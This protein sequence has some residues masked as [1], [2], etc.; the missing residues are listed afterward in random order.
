MKDTENISYTYIFE[1]DNGIK[2]KFVID[3]DPKTLN[4]IE[5]KK[6]NYPP[7]TKT[8]YMQCKNCSQDPQKEPY[9][10]IATGIS[11]IIELFGDMV[12][13]EKGLITVITSDRTILKHTSIQE[14]ISSLIGIY[15]VTSSCPVMEKLKPMV[16]Y[17]LPFASLNETTYRAT[18]MYLLG[19]YFIKKHGGN[20]DWDFSELTKI[21]SEV[22]K[23]NLDMSHRIQ[24]A[25][26]EDAGI[27][28]IV[29][30]DTFAKM[31]PI[32]I[33]TTL[34]KMEYLFSAYLQGF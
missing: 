16:R 9:C 30:L 23:L 34:D 24:S 26:K 27:N 1:L 6:D 2:K 15:M 20:P 8:S 11:N 13:Y 4:R 5:A 10:P 19:Q 12:S 28:A 29:I 7:W 21:Y 18:S 31:L 25:S 14:G 33:D 17:H 22:A 3:L 32:S